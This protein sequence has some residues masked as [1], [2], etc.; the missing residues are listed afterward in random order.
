MP[1][2][3]KAR[4]EVYLPDLPRRAYQDLLASLE[5]EFSY[6]FGGCTTVRGLEG[7]IFR[8]RVL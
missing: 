3:E 8:A 6:S 4:I 2:S 7:I 5:R 1:L